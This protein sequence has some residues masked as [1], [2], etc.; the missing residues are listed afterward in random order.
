MHRP[1]VLRQQLALVLQT[2]V[3]VP[4][5][6]DENQPAK[7]LRTAGIDLVWGCSLRAGPYRFI[8]GVHRQP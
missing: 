1:A 4:E 3:G 6:R 7:R 8:W 2:R 5:L